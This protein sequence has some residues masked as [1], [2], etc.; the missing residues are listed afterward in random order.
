[1]PGNYSMRADARALQISYDLNVRAGTTVL[2][3]PGFSMTE[4]PALLNSWG[5]D[6]IQLGCGTRNAFN[7][8]AVRKTKQNTPWWLEAGTEICPA[9][10]QTYVI[11]TEYRCAACDGPLCGVCVESTIETEI[12]CAGCAGAESEI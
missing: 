4:K 9:C 7:P 2:S 5:L 11:Q 3:S 1:V 6:R 12:I 8:I 10:S